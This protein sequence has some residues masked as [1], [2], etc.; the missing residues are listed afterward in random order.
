MSSEFH[1]KPSDGFPMPS[2][3]P[4]VFCFNK[5]ATIMSKTIEKWEQNGRHFDW[6]SKGSVL[7]GSDSYSYCYDQPFQ[8]RAT[9]NPKFKMFCIPKIGIQAPT[10]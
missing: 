1:W 7:E 5:L 2:G 4:I 8:N 9:G 6:I 10:V 3:F